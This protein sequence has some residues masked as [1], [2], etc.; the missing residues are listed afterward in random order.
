M[1]NEKLL[2]TNIISLQK[3]ET[4]FFP[5]ELC[6]CIFNVLAGDSA[7]VINKKV[8]ESNITM[9]VV[10]KIIMSNTSMAVLLKFP[11]E[12]KKYR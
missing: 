6:Q 7:I 9:I 2:L 1:K 11:L 4:Y 3:S 10:N 5:N 8:G 12:V